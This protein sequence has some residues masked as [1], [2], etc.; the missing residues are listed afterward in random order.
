MKVGVPRAT[1]PLQ[2]PSTRDMGSASEHP[3]QDVRSCAQEPLA[4]AAPHTKDPDPP[5]RP[6]R[7][8]LHPHRAGK[9]GEPTAIESA[10]PPSREPAL[11]PAIR[12]AHAD[13]RA[14]V[15]QL[16]YSVQTMAD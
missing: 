10:Q 11:P 4:C 5:D 6:S 15:Y 8:T 1:P 16:H 13:G 3:A 14:L 9:K 2:S 7:P 12:K